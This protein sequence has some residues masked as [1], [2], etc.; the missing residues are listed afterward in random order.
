MKI[1]KFGGSSVGTAERIKNVVE[2]VIN[3]QKTNGNIAVVFSAFQGVTDLLIDAANI[4]ANGNKSYLNIYN[5]LYV[6]HKEMLY[7]LIAAPNTQKYSTAI[8]DI[9][10]ELSDLLHGVFLIKELTPKTLDYVMSFGERLSAKIISF[11]LI[12]K[13]ITAVFCDS[14]LIIKTDDNFGSAKVNLVD[15]YKKIKDYFNSILEMQ[16]ITGF[17][18]SNSNNQT[19]TLGR[20]GSDYSAAIFGAALDVEEIE[21]WTDVNG[22]LTADPRKVKNA[23][24]VLSLTYEEA[25][26]LSHF[27][28]K[29]IHPPTMYPAM[30]KN[31]PIRIKNTFNPDFVGTFI[32]SKKLTEKEIYRIKG[33]S[34][35]DEVS[36]LRIQGPGMVGVAGIAKRLFGSLASAGINIIL[37]T[38]ASSEHS[39]CIAV[40]PKY[41]VKA[42]NI[43]ETEFVYEIKDGIVNE[44]IVENE[45]SII[46]VVG[47]NMRL[48]AG[49]AGK[50]FQSLGKNGINIIAIAQGS[51]ELNI[52]M[53]I[54]KRE[55]EKALNVIHNEFFYYNHKT[56]SLFIAGTGNVG[57]TLL[58][59]IKKQHQTMLD[60][61]LID[62]KVVGLA[63]SKKMLFNTEGINLSNSAEL[64][65]TCVEV[66]KIP[67][68]FETI[69]NLNLPNSIFVDCTSNE[70]IANN[71][72]TLLSSCISVVA[73]NKKANSG[74]YEYYDKLKTITSGNVKYLYETNVGAGL[75]VINTIKDLLA[76][77]DEIIKIEGILSGTLSYIFNNFD[78]TKT[79]SEIVKETQEKGFTEPDPRDDLNGMD[80]V[81]KLLILIREAG[82]KFEIEDIIKEDF[83][84][85]EIFNTYSVAE[86]YYKLKSVDSF[87]EQK[88]INAKNENKK[89]RYI[90]EYSNGKA[91]IKLKAVDVTNPFYGITAND[92]MIVL[93]TKYYNERP[94]IIQGPGAGAVVTAGGVFA[95]IKKIVNNLV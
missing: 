47:E 37:I 34:S 74:K 27:G 73:A 31:I 89:L 21:I 13:N 78:G 3:S 53:V 57:K 28:A 41:C 66:M 71:Y 22:V 62:I 52:S 6:K 14:R 86:F 30:V 56:I 23:F 36:L 19:T 43:I 40:L 82:Y 4:A 24:S 93:T 15:T 58:S 20:G 42:K 63:N 17:I 2:I 87:F 60:K 7:A 79:F 55:L 44:V 26:E 10:K 11:C 59:H 68:F 76:S 61:S 25:M 92:N 49:N 80:V 16:I 84:P 32:G 75:P 50:V 77:G 9:L 12:E 91:E 67:L 54:A 72:Y 1:L 45:L 51:S 38:Q 18:G 69:I 85:A 46:A 90:A 83:I 64:L 29:V 35:I 5:N 39:I 94:L 65:D 48:T 88:R 81:R 33:I 70:D 95:D 8:D